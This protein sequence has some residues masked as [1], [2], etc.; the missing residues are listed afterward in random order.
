MVLKR[1]LI[2]LLLM[3]PLATYG[4][5]EDAMEQWM[6]DGGSE[7][8]AA[9][10]HDRLMELANDPINI[11]DTANLTQIPF[12]TP[13]RI[14]ALK[15]YIRLYGELLSLK[16]L[17]YVSGFDST[18]ITLITPLVSVAPCATQE[19]WHIWQ[20]RHS[21]TT[22][23]GGTVEQAKGYSNGKYEGDNLRA[24]LCYSYNYHNKVQLRFTADKD[25]AEAWGKGNYYGYH[26]MLDGIGPVEKLVVGRYNLRFGQGL[27]LWTGLRPF[28][29]TGTTPV[30]FG[31]G[32]RPAG[33]FNEEDYQEGVAA[34][35]N[36]W[37][38]LY[39]SGF[40]SQTGGERLLGGHAEWRGHNYSIG[41]TITH[42]T[43]ADS[44]APRNYVYNKTAFRG[45]K[46][47][48]AGIDA[49]WQH[50]RTLLYGEASLSGN[51]KP[52]A[53]A[54]ITLSASDRN[55]I[56]VNLR[57]YHPQYHNLHSQG[58]SLG[59]AQSE[60]GI[61]LD[62]QSQ[63]PFGLHGLLSL[64]LH[65]FSTLRYADYHP[66][67][68]AWLRAQ[69]ERQFGRY[70][71]ASARYT[72]LQKERNI[73]NFDSILYTGEQTFRHQL[74]GEAKFT[75][76]AW[77]LT[78]RAM[79]ACFDAEQSDAQYGRLLVGNVRYIQPKWQANAS[80][81]WFHTDGYYAR[82]Y[83]GESN[84][85]YAWTMPMLY[86]H[87]LRG[88]LLLRYSPTHNFSLAAK[89]AIGYYPEQDS[90]GSGDAQTDGPHRQTW[91][92]QI[93]WKF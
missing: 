29:I 37:R 25:P 62:A 23:I 28:D 88:S 22:G 7:S 75:L 71:Y 80:L 24:L 61:R 8:E 82:F 9:D 79:W 42:N 52:A 59:N 44:L 48:N 57:Y 18:T 35:V 65:R 12:L 89:Y 32:V 38:T 90:I 86:G 73:P 68:G 93:R 30:R 84:I 50:G 15:N 64:D 16:E 33:A 11:N 51:G 14:Q 43:L 74:Q 58:Y 67:S 83:V 41:T 26:L 5:V 63:L 46:L 54:G 45:T 55:S 19:H 2:L 4:Q 69:L 3:L 27:T 6:L 39:L 56:G 34:T 72:Y 49:A 10:M 20:G 40:A 87:G 1:W 91:H 85:Q 70:L 76:A 21:L 92:L 13:F 31:N 36:A 81:A 53:T 47:F 77:Q 17:R 78:A 66:S 60:Q